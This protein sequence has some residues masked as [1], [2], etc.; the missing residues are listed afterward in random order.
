M[1]FSIFT[2]VA[3]VSASSASLAVRR[4]DVNVPAMTNADGVVVPFD[5]AGVVQP[6]KKRD[7]EQKKRDLAQRKRHIS[8]KRRAVSQEKQQQQKQ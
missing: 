8:R 4:V 3:L 7:L 2:L 6:A 5:T 1:R